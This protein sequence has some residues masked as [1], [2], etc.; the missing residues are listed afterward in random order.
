M[1]P[2]FESSLPSLRRIA[3]LLPMER[4][5]GRL[6]TSFPSVD[7]A[8]L[9]AVLEQEAE[10]VRGRGGWGGVGAGVWGGRGRVPAAHQPSHPDPPAVP[11]PPP[12]PPPPPGGPPPP[13]PPPPLP[14]RVQSRSRARLRRSA[15]SAVLSRVWFLSRTLPPE[16][17]LRVQ[18]QQQQRGSGSSSSSPPPRI[19]IRRRLRG[20]GGGEG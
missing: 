7:L 18:P 15:L 14:P 19:T 13:P 3:S 12:P 4:E 1:S 16:T 5:V 11:P 10:R 9:A 8:D 20:L 2:E 17:E 6:F